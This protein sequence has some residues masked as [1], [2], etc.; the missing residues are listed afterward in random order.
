MTEPPVRLCCF[1][2]HWGPGCPDGTVMCCSC[3]EKVKYEDLAV[4]PADGLRID[5][6]KP[7]HQREQYLLELHRM[8]DETG[9]DL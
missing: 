7:C 2:R 4:D 9:M 1:T 3:F 8:A 6:C 5:M